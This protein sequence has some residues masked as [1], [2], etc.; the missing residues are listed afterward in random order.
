MSYL[1]YVALFGE[2]AVIF[3]WLRDVRIFY[4]TGLTGYRRAAYYGVLYG[5]LGTFG[6]LVA[7]WNPGIEVVGIGIIMAA[8]FLQERN[9][10]EKIWKD[11]GTWERFLGS[12]RP[13]K[14]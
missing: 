5:A 8:L 7:L 1:L 14:K 10:R 11:E 4:R 13:V 3:L 6:F 9:A 12:V 2:I